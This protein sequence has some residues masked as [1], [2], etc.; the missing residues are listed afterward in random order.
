MTEQKG[1]DLIAEV[2]QR[3]AQ[4][5]DA[6][7]VFLGT[8]QPKYHRLIESL[9]RRCPDRIALR[10]EFNNPLSHRIEAGAD[11]FLM[12]SRFEPCGLNQLYSLKYGTIP[13]VRATGGLADTIVGFGQE[14]PADRRRT[15]FPSRNTARWP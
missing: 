9:S 11:M 4:T 15:A 3:S 7:W 2:L 12:P 14:S 13:V 6:Q 5:A 1:F 8:G 10:Q